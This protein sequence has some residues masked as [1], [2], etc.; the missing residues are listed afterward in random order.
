MKEENKTDGPDSGE[1]LGGYLKGKRELLGFSLQDVASKTK[2]NLPYLESIENEDF[3]SLP[4]EVFVKGFLRAYAKVVGIHEREVLQRYQQWKTDHQA[5]VGAVTGE[6]RPLEQITVRPVRPRWAGAEA[7]EDTKKKAIMYIL[8]ILVVLIALMVLFS[9]KN[10]EQG[11]SG[12]GGKGLEALQVPPATVLPETAGSSEVREPE[13]PKEQAKLLIQAIDRSWVSIVIDDGV[14]KE[15][16]LHPKDQV[17]VTGERK[18]ILTIGNA[19][20]VRVSLNGKP[21]GPYGKKGE[22]VKG[23]KVEVN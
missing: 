5:P 7:P 23:I 4:N 8:Y 21:L 13:K 10:V 17:T 22:I 16:S 9:K 19:G 20:G 1:S 12:E 6:N 18:F 11:H 14:T 2:I 3:L 15:F